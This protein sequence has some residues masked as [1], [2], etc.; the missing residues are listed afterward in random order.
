[1]ATTSRNRSHPVRTLIIFGVITVSLYL[2]MGFT[3]AWV[4]K[5]GLDLSGG[6]TITLSAA[7][8]TGQGAVDAAS[9]ELARSIIEQRVNG[10]GVREAEVTTSGERQIIVAAPNV[11]KDDLAQLVGQT[12]Q[13]YFRKVYWVQENGNTSNPS[14]DDQ[15]DLDLGDLDLGDLDL[16]DL[17]GLDID[18]LDD[19]DLGEVDPNAPDVPEI[20]PPPGQNEDSTPEVS[21]SPTAQSGP[22]LPGLPIPEPSP[23]PRAP[24][25]EKKS[26][27]DH[28]AWT[29][30]DRD[31][32][33][34]ARFY[35]GDKWWPNVVDQPYVACDETNTYKYLLGP[36]L[37]S[38]QLLENAYAGIPQNSISWLVSLN[39]NSEGAAAFAEVT[40]KLATLSEPNNQFGIVLDNTVIS[41]PRVNEAITGGSAQIE[42]S[43]TQQSA[44]QLANILKYGALPLTFETS[45][46][47]TVSAKLGADQLNAGLLAGLIGLALVVIYA[48]FYY[49]G[50][51][52]VVVAS[53]AI[54]FLQ[55]Y[56]M[57][58]I[59]GMG[60]GYAL[61]LPGIAGVI[62]AIG[63]TA[64]SFIIYFERIRD[65]AREGRSLR[66]AIESGWKR[67]I[68]TILI[69]DSVSLLSAL[70]LWIL[71]VG[72]VKG[73]AF[74]LGLTTLI[75]IGIVIC[76]TK[77]LMTLLG[78]TKFF[79]EGRRFSGFEADH[80][81]TRS[82]APVAATSGGSK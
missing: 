60:M 25:V 4:P 46:I 29:P 41:A 1:M 16:D 6:T 7:N 71:A 50:L 33:D 40:A 61:N 32:A 79:G 24:G 81:G 27:T 54:A 44:S 57:I 36:A 17:D 69:A 56:A 22:P 21:S 18:D 35:C 82:A 52:I 31:Y 5:L 37:I 77:P 64:D 70:V 47:D 23:R 14:Q 3:N 76:F 2:I 45:N 15:G 63:I 67:S 55:T 26:V 65:E 73:F 19:L 68:K 34:Y 39:F 12:A 11:Q 78:R 58:S 28:L 48:V 38:G 49:R 62:V 53:L 59:L 8:I 20:N 10:S 80:L 66:T 75:D 74:T 43:F 72:A 30:D 13:L 42:G 51:A 9:L